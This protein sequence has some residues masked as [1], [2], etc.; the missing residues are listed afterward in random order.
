MQQHVGKEKESILFRLQRMKESLMVVYWNCPTPMEMIYREVKS[1][2]N[3]VMVQEMACWLTCLHRRIWERILRWQQ[4]Q[5]LVLLKK[6]T[7]AI[8]LDED[9]QV[10]REILKMVLQN[11]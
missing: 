3:A 5:K 1:V 7:N 2:V 6:L 10:Y 4:I 8:V 11:Y 9:G